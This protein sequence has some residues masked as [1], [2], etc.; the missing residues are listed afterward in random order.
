[1]HTVFSHRRRRQLYAS[2]GCH[3]DGHNETRHRQAAQT[4]RDQ[5]EDHG[6]ADCGSRGHGTPDAPAGHHR[7]ICCAVD[8]RCW[9]DTRRTA[10][11]GRARP[12]SSLP[13]D[14]WTATVRRPAIT[15][16]ATTS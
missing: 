8:C 15:A 11:T 5:V 12:S 2:Q 16:V 4:A 9:T 13:C 14:P 10:P 1:M 3:H 7:P 6:Q